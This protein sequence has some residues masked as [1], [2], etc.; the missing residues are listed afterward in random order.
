MRLKRVPK[1]LAVLAQR[2]D[3]ARAHQQM[4]SLG[5][6][7]ERPSGQCHGKALLDE[8]FAKGLRQGE[9][10]ARAVRVFVGDEDRD[11]SRARQPLE[12]ESD[13]P[14]TLNLKREAIGAEEADEQVDVG[15]RVEWQDPL[16]SSPGVGGECRKA[17][18]RYDGAKQFVF[19]GTKAADPASPSGFGQAETL[20]PPG[21]ENCSVELKIVT[22]IEIPGVTLACGE[23]VQEAQEV[24]VKEMDAH[25]SSVF[26]SSMPAARRRR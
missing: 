7:G 4:I 9:A 24:F 20:L 5:P 21:G 6:G 17:I 18:L 2:D 11:K 1:L 13:G 10:S 19:L 15:S 16:A 14:L 23:R 22:L 8:A 25:H 26:G 3:L 12:A